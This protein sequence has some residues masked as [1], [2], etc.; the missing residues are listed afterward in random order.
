MVL[1]FASCEK[2]DIRPNHDRDGFD[3]F[4]ADEEG[5]T[6]AGLDGGDGSGALIRDPDD[7]EDYDEDE[8][9]IVDPDDDED[10]DENEG[11]VDPDDDEDFDEDEGK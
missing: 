7:D 4:T 10:F 2:E 1:A 9:S 11:I 8:D 5:N 6:R 3:C